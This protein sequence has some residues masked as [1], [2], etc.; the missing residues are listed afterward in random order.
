MKYI[1]PYM[2]FAGLLLLGCSGE[3]TK[4]AAHKEVPTQETIGDY[5]LSVV[6]SSE[7]TYGYVILKNQ[8][9]FIEQLQ[10]PGIR[11]EQGFANAQSAMSVARHVVWKMDH[12]IL[13]P[14]I[15]KR[16]LD[17]LGVTW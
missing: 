5:T 11:T 15:T 2:F 7:D 17:S 3:N 1:I 8:R 9:L 10:V 14:T 13:P 6:P 16:E 4:E 12:N